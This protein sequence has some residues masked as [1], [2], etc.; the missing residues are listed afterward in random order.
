MYINIYIYQ[1]CMY[2]QIYIYTYTSRFPFPNHHFQLP[3]KKKKNETP[4]WDRCHYRLALDTMAPATS[5]HVEWGWTD[6]GLHQQ[7]CVCKEIYIYM[8]RERD[9]RWYIYICISMY[10]IIWVYVISR[11][12]PWFNCFCGSRAA[13]RFQ[14]VS[15]STVGFG[16]SSFDAICAENM[17]A[18]PTRFF[19]Q[20]E[21]VATWDYT[22]NAITYTL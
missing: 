8:F 13:G 21:K 14:L 4:H 7:C 17:D 16:P 20:T 9:D 22:S 5:G 12:C 15:R 1:L 19:A 2:V 10:E 18:G 3:R 6:T 11:L